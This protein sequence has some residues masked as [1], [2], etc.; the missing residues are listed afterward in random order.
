MEGVEGGVGV[1]LSGGCCCSRV[2]VVIVEWIAHC[3]RSAEI[4]LVNIFG[5]S[6]EICVTAPSMTYSLIFSHLFLRHHTITKLVSTHST[7]LGTQPS[8]TIR[9]AYSI[10]QFYFSSPLVVRILFVVNITPNFFNFN[11]KLEVKL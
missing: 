3:K 4:T 7:G 9:T 6:S 8:T 10:H 5:V 2:A 11:L 1:F